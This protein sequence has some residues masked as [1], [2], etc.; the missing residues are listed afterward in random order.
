MVTIY[1]ANPQLP[2]EARSATRGILCPV[3]MSAC[4]SKPYMDGETRIGTSWMCVNCGRQARFEPT[5]E[6]ERALVEEN[7]RIE[8]G[9]A[10]QERAENA[11]ARVYGAC[12]ATKCGWPD[13]WSRS[14][15]EA[16]AAGRALKAADPSAKVVI[17]RG[18]RHPFVRGEVINTIT[19]GVVE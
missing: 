6:Y 4:T 10:E 19:E 18:Q 16:L 1:C 13:S 3:C 11:R 9:M 8:E 14:Y 15:D 5:A 12:Y 17:L 2:G 7:R